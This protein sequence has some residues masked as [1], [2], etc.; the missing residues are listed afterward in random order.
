MVAG[1]TSLSLRMALTLL[2]V[3]LLVTWRQDV[4]A[5]FDIKC[6]APMAKVLGMMEYIKSN[7][8]AI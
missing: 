4:V 8:T 2:L 6:Y 7:P 1:S 3:A 5:S